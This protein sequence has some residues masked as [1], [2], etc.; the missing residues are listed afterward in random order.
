MTIIYADPLDVHAPIYRVTIEIEL[1]V[2][3]DGDGEDAI[4]AA[5]A[6]LEVHADPEDVRFIDV[7]SVT[8][9]GDWP[10]PQRD[11]WC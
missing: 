4:M 8:S 1:T 7:R 2:C 5:A 11:R 3:V 10:L 6:L 9:D